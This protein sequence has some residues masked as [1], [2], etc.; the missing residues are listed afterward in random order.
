M[1]RHAD[2]YE[3]YDRYIAATPMLTPCCQ[4]IIYYTY[5]RLLLSH[6]RRCCH[7]IDIFFAITLM[8]RRHLLITPISRY[9]MLRHDISLRHAYFR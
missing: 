4:A 3:R 2:A 6:L 5:C 9:A 7:D 1:L 8:L